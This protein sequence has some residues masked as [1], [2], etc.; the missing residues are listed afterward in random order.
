MSQF[1]GNQRDCGLIHL[2]SRGTIAEVYKRP[3]V[4]LIDRRK[5]IT[6]CFLEA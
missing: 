3:L 4:P 2:V 5:W 6:V 1:C